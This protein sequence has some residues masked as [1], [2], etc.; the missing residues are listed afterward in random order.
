MNDNESPQVELYLALIRVL[1]LFAAA[2]EED[3]QEGG[4]VAEH[5]RVGRWLVEDLAVTLESNL[6]LDS[7]EQTGMPLPAFQAL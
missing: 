6:P 2:I 3:D 1:P 5:L 4:R 7:L